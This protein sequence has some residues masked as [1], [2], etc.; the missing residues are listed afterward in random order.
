[1]F[2]A[3]SIG[4]V[5]VHSLGGFIVL[6][7]VYGLMYAAV[8]GNQR[9]YVSDLATAQLRATAL[10]AFQTTTGL[11]ALPAG[12][13]AGFLWEKIGPSATFIYGATFGLASILLFII[14]KDYFKPRPQHA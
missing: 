7:A 9:A 5:I 6:F 8:D 2:S 11:M 14:F 12:L 4:F 1:M 3:T 10:G 13:I